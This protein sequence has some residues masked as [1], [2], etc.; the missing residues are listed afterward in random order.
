LQ[1]QLEDIEQEIKERISKDEELKAKAK[2][3]NLSKICW[4]K[5]NHDFVSRNA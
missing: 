3:I 5:N 4:R 1:R 2:A